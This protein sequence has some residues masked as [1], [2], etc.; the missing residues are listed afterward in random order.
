MQVGGTINRMLRL[1]RLANTS[2]GLMSDLLP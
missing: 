1:C 2:Y